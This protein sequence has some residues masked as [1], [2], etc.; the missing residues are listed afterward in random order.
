MT[1]VGLAAVGLALVVGVAIAPA[2]LRAEEVRAEGVIFDMDTIVHRAGE[3]TTKD[4]RKVP[5]GTAELVEGKLGKAVKFSFIEAAGAGSFSARVQGSSAWDEAAGF[6]MWVKGDGSK[7]WG[8]IELID[9]DDYGLRYAYCFPI[10]STEWRK[11]VV[12]WSDLTP[13]LAGPMVGPKAKGGFA[14]SRFGT[15]SFG[16]WFFWRDY[17]AESYTI[18]QV[19]LEASIPAPAR[20]E[21]TPGLARLRAKLERH[22]PVT[23]VTMGDSVTDEHH[24]ANRQVVWHKLL[25]KALEAK[26]GSRVTIVNPAIGGTALS[27]NMVLMPRW[28]AEAPSPD[29]VTVWFGYNDWDSGVRGERF[30]EYLRVAVERI[31]RQTAGK[32]DVLLITPC[33]GH[34]R[35]ETMME[36]EQAVRDVAREQKTGL[37]DAAAAFRAAGSADEALKRE[38]WVSDKVHL[39]PRGHELV[40]DMVMGAIGGAAAAAP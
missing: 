1:R 29:L 28:Q 12:P 10:D 5:A 4:N 39:A 21:F 34:E 18:D 20:V 36:L 30:A 25:A 37:A 40:R 26:Y 33:P 2:G 38:Y 14:P 9:K 24:W 32:A 15:F 7:S 16:K 13:E 6:S 31:R 22:E 35:W 23:I 8:G 17:P 11:I 3:T 27:Q 19:G